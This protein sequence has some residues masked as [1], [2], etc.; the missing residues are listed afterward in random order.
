MSVLSDPAAHDRVRAV[1]WRDGALELLDQRLLPAREFPMDE[2]GRTRFR[3]RFRETFEG[4]PS[5]CTVYKD[6]SNGIAPAGIE[7]Y[8]PLFFEQTA[9]VF[10]YLGE[11]AALVLH[12]EV[13]AALDEFLTDK[14]KQGLKP[15]SID[16]LG[17]RLRHF[18][19]LA[20]RV[21]N[22]SADQARQLYEAETVKTTRFGHVTRAQT[23]RKLLGAAKM[24]FCWAVSRKYSR[25]NPFAAVKPVGKPRVGKDQ[26][27]ID[28]ARRLTQVLLSAAEK[29]EEGAVAT[30]TQLVLG[31]RTSEVLAGSFAGTDQIEKFNARSGMRTLAHFNDIDA[32]RKSRL[33]KA[34]LF[35]LDDVPELDAVRAEYMRLAQMLWD[36]VEPA[37]AKPLK[38]REIFDL[39]GFD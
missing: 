4:D 24:F 38:D 20:Q 13:D 6:V 25:A 15:L 3:G 39:L 12:G 27:R 8:L 18:L 16:T 19:P 7:Y 23:H 10:D 33:K 35:E 1:A 2:A 5:R 31:L 9:T 37:D 26:L 34:T 28:E 30:Y 21:S 22:F 17:Y 32:I 36:G 29:G 11:Q 14:Q